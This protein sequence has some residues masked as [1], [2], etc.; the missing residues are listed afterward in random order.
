MSFECLE[1]FSNNS[2]FIDN[3]KQLKKYRK[4][5]DLVIILVKL[6]NFKMQLKSMN[7]VIKN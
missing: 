1:N 7:I 2:I 4:K 6:K 3:E 5:L